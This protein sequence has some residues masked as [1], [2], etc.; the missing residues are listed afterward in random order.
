MKEYIRY[1]I[2][3]FAIGFIL[4][5]LMDC[6]IHRSVDVNVVVSVAWGIVVCI[7][8]ILHNVTDTIVKEKMSIRKE[9]CEKLIEE[10]DNQINKLKLKI[11]KLLSSG[12]PGDMTLAGIYIDRVIELEKLKK[13]YELTTKKRENK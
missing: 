13:Q 3:Q 9:E 4:G 6:T 5:T 12:K 10:I 1:A 8:S 11:P 2:V 7:I